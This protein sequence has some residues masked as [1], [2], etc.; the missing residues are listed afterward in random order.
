MSVVTVFIPAPLRKFTGGAEQVELEIAPG[1][2]KNV[3]GVIADL[4][5]RFPGL[6][7]QL[8]E[9][10]GLAGGLAVFIGGEQAGLGL[11]A[12]V[13]PGDELFFLT[14]IA[15]GGRGKTEGCGMP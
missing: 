2:N 7:E 9:G 13:A 4:E 10:D 6:E 11:L 3:R 1:E 15:G 14:P 8:L 12:K 5:R